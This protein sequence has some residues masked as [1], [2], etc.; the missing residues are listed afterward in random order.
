MEWSSGTRERFLK[1]I[2][3]LSIGHFSDNLKIPVEND[4]S[5]LKNIWNFWISSVSE[6]NLTSMQKIHKQR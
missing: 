6:I 1:D 4:K 3:E 2:T 5:V